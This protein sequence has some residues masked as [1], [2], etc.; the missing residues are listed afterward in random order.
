[1]SIRMLMSR[2][3]HCNIIFLITF[4]PAIH[5]TLFF[6]NDILGLD[7][8]INNDTS[9]QKNNFEQF[10]YIINTEWLQDSSRRKYSNTW[11]KWETSENGYIE[12]E[13]LHRDLTF[14]FRNPNVDDWKELSSYFVRESSVLSETGG[15]GNLNSVGTI[16]DTFC[17]LFVSMQK[18]LSWWDM[19]YLRT[20]LKCRRCM[21]LC[22]LTMNRFSCSSA[23]ER[24]LWSY[25]QIMHENQHLKRQ[26]KMRVSSSRRVV[27]E[28]SQSTRKARTCVRKK[29]I[30]VSVQRLMIEHKNTAN[31]WVRDQPFNIN[32]SRSLHNN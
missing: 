17:K 7:S 31:R 16:Q 20:H 27:I 6:L 26:K 10:R 14:H 23:W 21:I 29:L 11:R 13:S 15:L 12:K 8:I 1:M 32:C 25:Q 24:W 19:I 22:C 5:L 30:S 9:L 18:W 3:N 28:R 2:C 4:V